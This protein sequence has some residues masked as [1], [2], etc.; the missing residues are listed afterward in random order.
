M[1]AM[2]DRMLMGGPARNKLLVKG[3]SS[4]NALVRAM[5]QVGAA[6]RVG[7]REGMLPYVLPIFHLYFTRNI[8]MAKVPALDQHQGCQGWGPRRGHR[9]EPQAIF[10]F[11]F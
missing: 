6:G 5:K 10:L 9:A 11:C 7:K 1:R 4:F 3:G 8:Y 2:K